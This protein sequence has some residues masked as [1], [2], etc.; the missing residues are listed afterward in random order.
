[1]TYT[2]EDLKPHNNKFYAK[3]NNPNAEIKALEEIRERY[4]D[5]KIKY[6]SAKT[7]TSPQAHSNNS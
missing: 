1:M 7:N 3:H 6:L 4:L 2:L 5:K